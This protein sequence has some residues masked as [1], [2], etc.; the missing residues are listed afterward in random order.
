MLGG[1]ETRRTRGSPLPHAALDVRVEHLGLRRR[2]RGMQRPIAATLLLLLVACTPSPSDSVIGSIQVDA[3]AGPVC[4]VERDPPDP[5]CAPRPVEGALILV[6][7][8]DGRDIVVA[9]GETDSEGRVLLDVPPGNYVV[10]GAP[11][12]GLMGAPEPIAVT[13][14][15]NDT[16][17]VA[18]GYDTGIR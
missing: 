11:V 3:L 17:P 14:Q 12:E 2:S 16:T 18:L 1:I 5:D 10:I 7:P 13:V 6:Q 8:A 4:P 9:Q 15:A